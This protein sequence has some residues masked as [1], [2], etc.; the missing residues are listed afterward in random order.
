M[1]AFAWVPDADRRATARALLCGLA[2]GLAVGM[3][4]TAAPLLALVGVYWI[5]RGARLDGGA[6]HVGAFVLGTVLLGAPWYL[7]NLLL[8]GNPFFPAAIGPFDGPFTAEAQSATA[9]APVLAA[10]WSEPGALGAIARRM[11]D[12]P[13]WLGL[14]AG[15]GY[16]VGLWALI[17]TRDRLQRV[18]ISLMLL[19]GLGFLA[20]FPLA[21]FSG[22]PNRADAST[23]YYVRYITFWFL[24]GLV[25]L[26]SLLPSRAPSAAGAPSRAGL[27]RGALA[28]LMLLA[29]VALAASTPARRLAWTVPRGTSRVRCGTSS[30]R[31]GTRWSGCRTAPA[32]PCTRATRP[33][34]P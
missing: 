14:A 34:T 23:V 26:P 18:H 9:L 19:A 10:A 22:T 4:P 12:W 8:S 16:V 13:L 33:A 30:D 32:S 24:N 15:A 5:W 1:L 21:P 28:G 3:K 25:L 27:P 20:L 31:D 17:R 6:R 7:R 11:L 29:L 2:G